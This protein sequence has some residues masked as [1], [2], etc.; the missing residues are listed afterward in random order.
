MLV[1][2]VTAVAGGGTPSWGWLDIYSYAVMA[3]VVVYWLWDR[4]MWKR[5]IAQRLKIAP[6]DVSG[7]WRGTLTSCWIDPSN[8]EQCNP[9][10]VYLVVRQ[11]ASTVSAILLTNEARSLSSLASVNSEDGT[12][13]ID[14]MYEGAPDLMYQDRSRVHRGAVHLNII[15]QPVERLRGHYWTDRDSK[16]ELEFLDRVAKKAEDTAQAESLFHRTGG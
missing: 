1:F 4:V 11:T 8:G 9:K 12:S 3:A 5:P 6:R 13:S 10:T 16:G 15:G 7:T 14:Y 2:A